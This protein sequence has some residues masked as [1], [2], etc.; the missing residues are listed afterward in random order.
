M[1]SQKERRKQSI[2]KFEALCCSIS[3]NCRDKRSKSSHTK[4]LFVDDSTT[5]DLADHVY[6]RLS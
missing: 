5:K 6:Y 1:S 2:E 3:E 4:N